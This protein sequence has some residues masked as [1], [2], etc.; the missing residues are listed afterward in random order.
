M[1]NKEKIGLSKILSNWDFF[2][3]SMGHFI[4][5]AGD[6]IDVVAYSIMVYRLTGSTLVMGTLLAI[7]AMPSLLLGPFAGV[8]IDRW[9]KKKIIILGDLGRAILVGFTAILYF[10]GYIQVYH[11]Y[12][13][14]LFNSIFEIFS[15]SARGI[16]TVIMVER[17]DIGTTQAFWST[18]ETLA[19]IIGT[20]CAAAIIALFGISGA[21]LL[22]SITFLVAML[23]TLISKIPKIENNNSPLTLINFI[24][25]F[26]EG[27]SFISHNNM[28]K[29]V[30]ILSIIST[31]VFGPIDI[32]FPKYSTD[33]IKAGETG[34]SYITLLFSIGILI[35]ALL[36]GQI[37]NR[38]QSKHIIIVSF[39]F[40]GIAYAALSLAKV[41]LQ[42]VTV[43]FIMGIFAA[44]LMITIDVII[45]KSV[46]PNILGR[47]ITSLDTL[48]LASRPL[49]T[50]LTG[51]VAAYLPVS[52]VFLLCGILLVI[53]A[54]TSTFFKGY[55]E[56]GRQ[57]NTNLNAQ[58]KVTYGQ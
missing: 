51:F 14:T 30:I 33:V 8:M 47:V 22:D 36:L 52:Q 2:M 45:K 42:A 46:P 39:I 5:R 37:K 57:E 26:K 32:L 56:I 18:G 31:F 44:F 12:I 50:S 25:E 48:K 10:L 53:A 17:E 7:N 4:S 21:I 43:G 20:G 35:G 55:N 15:S 58:E 16:L 13:F 11:L 24:N 28:L 40:L 41:L 1:E 9:P 27:I 6:S 38:I 54:V 23:F 29:F 19:S 3:V 49:S 34:F